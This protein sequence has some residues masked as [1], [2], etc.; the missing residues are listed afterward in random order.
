MSNLVRFGRLQPKRNALMKYILTTLFW[1]VLLVSSAQTKRVLFVGNSY[2]ASNNLPATINSLANSL[3]DTLIYDSNTPGGYRFLHHV[4]NTTTLNKIAL[5]GWDF[6]SLQAQSQEPS[7]SPAQVSSEVYPHA[8][9][10]VDSIKSADACVEPIFY[11]TWGRKNGDAANCAA[12]PPVCTYDGMQQRLRE[13]YLEMGFDNN[14]TVSPVGAVWKQVRDSVPLLELYTADESHPS[15]AGTYL[16]ACTFYAAMWRKSPVGA[17]FI[18]SLP[19]ADAAVIQYFADK[20]V[21]D[22]LSTWYIGHT[23]ISTS[24][25]VTHQ[26]GATYNFSDSSQNADSVQWTTDGTT[27]TVPAGQ[28]VSH[29]FSDTGLFQI[30]LIAFNGCQSDTVITNQYVSA[31]GIEFLNKSNIRLYPNPAGELVRISSNSNIQTVVLMDFQGKKL[32]LVEN[33]NLQEFE[34]RVGELAT[35]SYLVEVGTNYGIELH[36]IVVE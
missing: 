22:S 12:Y 9:T 20:V 3:G 21:L 34:F 1:S 16:A 23:D 30:E 18:S 19:A 29:T 7:F 11:M 15:P 36:R 8:K 35:G 5:G 33:I 17:S 28:L 31:V 32:R 10:L 13:S 24:A 27:T 2:T 14:A 26:S 25:N 4:S 6:V